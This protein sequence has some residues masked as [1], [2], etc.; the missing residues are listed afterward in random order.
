MPSPGPWNLGRRALVFT[1]AVFIVWGTLLVV[2]VLNGRSANV[3]G[4]MFAGICWG[5]IGNLAVL[6]GGKAAKTFSQIKKGVSR[7]RSDS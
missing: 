6:V 5:L 1:L 2:A 3:I 7:D 4:D